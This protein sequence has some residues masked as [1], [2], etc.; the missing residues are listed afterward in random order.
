VAQA[1]GWRY[2]LSENPW[3]AKRFYALI[4][5]AMFVAG[6]ISFVNI[7]PVRALYWSMVLAGACL[8][9]T[10]IFLILIGNDRRIMR[11]VN[12]KW[13]NFWIG[14]AAGGLFAAGIAWV[15][16]KVAR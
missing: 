11:T 8:I 4:S 13:Q 7:N 2:G 15:G 14:A 16:W 9:P 6:A 5:G 1:A 12:T 3:E 10:L